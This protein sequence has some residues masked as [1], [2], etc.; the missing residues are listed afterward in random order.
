MQILVFCDL[1]ECFDGGGEIGKAPTRGL[2]ESFRTESSDGERRV[3]PL[4]GLKRAAVGALIVF[5]PERENPVQGFV[6]AI[7]L[8]GRRDVEGLEHGFLETPAEPDQEAALAELI[9]AGDLRSD[10]FGGMER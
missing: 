1:V 9:E 6:E 7:S 2:S 5:G 10:F 3:R 4:V 8:L